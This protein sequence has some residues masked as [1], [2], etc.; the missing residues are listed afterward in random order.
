MTAA[1]KQPYYEEQSRLSRQHMEQHPEYRYRPRP[2]RT[3]IVDGRRLRIS[4]YKDLMRARKGPDGTRKQPWFAGSDNLTNDP[5]T[6]KIVNSI[7]GC[8]K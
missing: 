3:C 4:E 6:Q 1:D 8:K 7:L 5:Q 2:K